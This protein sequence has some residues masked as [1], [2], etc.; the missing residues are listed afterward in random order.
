[1]ITITNNDNNNNNN[2]NNTDLCQETH[3]TRKWWRRHLVGNW[4]LLSGLHFFEFVFIGVTKNALLITMSD[5]RAEHAGQCGKRYFL[6]NVIEDRLVKSS[7]HP[8]I[9]ASGFW[10]RRVGKTAEEFLLWGC[11]A[12]EI[13][14]L[15]SRSQNDCDLGSN[16]TSTET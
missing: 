11:H 14:P 13:T 16:L 2:N 8:F 6:Q 1:M 3:S 4:D 7:R 10:R 12:Y 5:V 15:R 9:A